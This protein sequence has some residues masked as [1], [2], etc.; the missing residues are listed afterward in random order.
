MLEYGLESF[1][2]LRSSSAQSKKSHGMGIA[3]EKR[4]TG[5]LDL[6]VLLLL[7]DHDLVETF[8]F[9]VYWPLNILLQK[10][11]QKEG[12]LEQYLFNPL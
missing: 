4:K 5:H 11:N 6:I 8:V 12:L 7:K 1:V 2:L 10:R 9:K 3:I